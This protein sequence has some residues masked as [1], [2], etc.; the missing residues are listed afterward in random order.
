MSRKPLPFRPAL[1]LNV[2]SV[3]TVVFQCL[4]GNAVAG[5]GA[6][7]ECVFRQAVQQSEQ[8][9][10]ISVQRLPNLVHGHVPFFIHLC[11]VQ[12]VDSLIVS[13]GGLFSTGAVLLH[14]PRQ[15]LIPG[16]HVYYGIPDRPV[17]Y[18]AGSEQMVLWDALGRI[19]ETLPFPSYLSQEHVL[20]LSGTSLRNSSVC[21][22]SLTGLNWDRL[23]GRLEPHQL[24]L[25]Q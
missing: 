25:Y 24:G 12:P 23:R 2:L 16:G 22:A 21:E 14:Q 9:G 1:P 3:L 8:P 6:M 4:G 5:V 13:V 17:A 18:G 20:E 19:Q 11:L 7:S 10:V 15:L